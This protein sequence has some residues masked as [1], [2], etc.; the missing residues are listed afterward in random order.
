M[1]IDMETE[2][3]DNEDFAEP[4]TAATPMATDSNPPP[5]DIVMALR[6]EGTSSSHHV[7]SNNIAKAEVRPSS[8]E[9]LI[10]NESMETSPNSIPRVDGWEAARAWLMTLPRRRNVDQ[11]EIEEW[12]QANKNTLSKEIVTMPRMHLYRYLVSQHKLIRKADQQPD[13][14]QLKMDMSKWLEP[15]TA[16]FKRSD[17]WKP[18]YS[19]LESLNVHGVVK[20]KAIDEWLSQNPEIKDELQSKHSRYHLIHYIQKCHT[21][22]L[23]KKER[24]FQTTGGPS[25]GSR[26]KQI[27]VD[28]GSIERKKIAT[29]KHPMNIDSQTESRKLDITVNRNDITSDGMPHNAENLSND[30]EHGQTDLSNANGFISTMKMGKD[31]AF[32]K[33]EILSELESRLTALISKYKQQLAVSDLSTTGQRLTERNGIQLLEIND[34]TEGRLRRRSRETSQ[35]QLD[36][37]NQTSAGQMRSRL[38]PEGKLGRKRKKAKDSFDISMYAWSRCEASGGNCKCYS[39]GSF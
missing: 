39:I 2:I 35:S 33:Y 22:I 27:S 7:N 28:K 6:C 37:V 18:I 14:P 23:K 26:K 20:T 17:K 12:L 24:T 19:W 25:G 21:K 10:S 16:R 3:P 30:M 1:E 9:T 8:S 4:E 5:K 31:E 38:S 36:L 34:D 15:P 13:C 32:K 11:S 29:D